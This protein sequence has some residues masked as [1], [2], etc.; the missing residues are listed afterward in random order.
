MHSVQ[1]PKPLF[2]SPEFK[3]SSEPQSSLLSVSSTPTSG[4]QVSWWHHLA[5]IV[6]RSATCSTHTSLT[7]SSGYLHLSTANVPHVPSTLDIF[8]S[9]V[10]LKL[11]FH[12]LCG[13]LSGPLAGNL[14]DLQGYSPSSWGSFMAMGM[15]F[16]NLVR[17]GNPE[18]GML[19]SRLRVLSYLRTR[20]TRGSEC[21]SGIC[22]CRFTLLV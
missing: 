21:P 17:P 20:E 18:R 1:F 6:S 15:A 10:Q 9:S 3:I 7:S 19:D 22:F 14:T 8:G 13:S 11:H 16:S 12:R 5:L 2:R 4:I